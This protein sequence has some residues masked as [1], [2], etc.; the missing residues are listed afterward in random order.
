MKVVILA[1]ACLLASVSALPNQ[2][3][4]ELEAALI[5]RNNGLITGQIVQ[6][7]ENVAQTI[8]DAGLDPLELDK[9]IEYALPV[10]SI[11]NLKAALRG[12]LF[13]GLSNI[14]VNRM[15]YAVLTS[16]L[17]FNVELPEIALSVGVADWD[18]NIFDRNFNGIVS[19]R[20]AVKNI[21]IAGEVRVSLG[22]ISGIS[23]RSMEVTLNVGNIESNLNVALQG[24]NYSHHINNYL[25]VTVPGT[26]RAY[27]S[28]INELITI[29]ATE[30]VEKNLLTNLN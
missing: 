25:G 18:V 5:T 9:E 30:V 23:L 12:F 26:L 27:Q 22:V 17:T 21:V 4:T 15:N 24:V 13:R 14:V 7:I 29:V 1:I 20:V 16:R 28:D 2:Q 3:F 11:L 10:P 6:Q 19:G 8:R